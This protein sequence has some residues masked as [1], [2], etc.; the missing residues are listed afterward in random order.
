MKKS[1]K[2]INS[3]LIAVFIAFAVDDFC[4]F[5]IKKILS[6]GELDIQLVKRSENDEIKENIKFYGF[7]IK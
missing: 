5:L 6:A 4:L 7:S 1:A 3:N 2:I